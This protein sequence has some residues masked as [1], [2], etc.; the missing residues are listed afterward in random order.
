M[1]MNKRTFSIFAAQ[2]NCAVKFTKMKPKY[3]YFDLDNTLINHS[4]AE[5]E[6]QR[7]T[8]SGFPEFE[9]TDM[10]SWLKAYTEEN[11]QL[12]QQYQKGTIDREHLQFQRFYRPMKNLGISTERS[13]EIGWAYMK[14]YRKYWTWVEGAREALEIVADRFPVGIVTNGFLETQQKKIEVMNLNQFT[15]NFIITEEIGVMKPHP[16]VFDIATERAGTERDQI[17]YVG[18]SYSSDVIGGRNAGWQ[19]AWFTAFMNDIEDEQTADF[20]FDQFP[21]LTHYLNGR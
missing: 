9:H 5:S 13:E 11:H 20:M 8:F 6:A 15:D 14:N 3:I 2:N 1:M 4:K 16:K 7:D 10:E 12:W 18:D 17:L 21:M 19:T